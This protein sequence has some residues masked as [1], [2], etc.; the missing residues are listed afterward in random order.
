MFSLHELIFTLKGEDTHP[1]NNELLSFEEVISC[2][3]ISSEY[4]ESSSWGLCPNLSISLSQDDLSEHRKPPKSYL[5]SGAGKF[6]LRKV[7]G[8]AHVKGA[9]NL[10]YHPDHQHTLKH[11]WSVI[12][13][14]LWADEYY[15]YQPAISQLI[16]NR[17]I[18]SQVSAG[19]TGCNTVGALTFVTKGRRN[20]SEGQ[21]CASL[22]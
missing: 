13:C 2:L 5:Q 11:C 4:W 15:C 8:D 7:F 3:I 22:L 1:W 18:W 16:W 9:I 14:E 17:F 12:F 21:K 10:Y 19:M 20:C 6:H